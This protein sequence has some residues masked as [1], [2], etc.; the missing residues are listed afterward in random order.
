MFT[1]SRDANRVR[2]V[3]AGVATIA[4]KSSMERAGVKAGSERAFGR[5]RD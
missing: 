2:Q 3:T 1:G 4:I 5:M